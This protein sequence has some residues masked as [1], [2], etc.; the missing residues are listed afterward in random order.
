MNS[1]LNHCHDGAGA[2]WII[3]AFYAIAVACMLTSAVVSRSSMIRTAA[4]LITAAWA[5][6]LF[7][8]L[9]IGKA[10]YFVLAFVIDA[11]L[12]YRFRIMAQRDLFPVALFYICL[13]EMAFICFAFAVVMDNFW[14]VFWLNRIFDLTLLYI[15]G[16]SLLRSRYLR[17]AGDKK[18]RLG[19]WRAQFAAT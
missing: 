13:V 5:Y 15:I 19:G 4:L 11:M 8:Y 3:I 9:Y 14:I 12:A 18:N 7:A 2:D 17:R 10:S 6:S 1:I 16:S